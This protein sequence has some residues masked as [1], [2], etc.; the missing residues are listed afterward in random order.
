[1][2]FGVE[3]MATKLVLSLIVTAALASFSPAL[4]QTPV[5]ERIVESIVIN[6]QTAQ[7]V[8]VVQNGGIQ[9]YTCPSP[10][11]YVTPD[12][13]ESGWACFE[14]TTG[15]WLLHAQPPRQTAYAY[16]QA[17]VYVPAPATTVYQYA[18]PYYAYPYSYYPY[19]YYP[20][21]YYPY[22]GSAFGFGFGF[23]YRSPVFV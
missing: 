1:M 22:S 8:L 19:G 14:P 15:M 13:A 9:S 7:G 17:S 12:R 18:P 23:A 16:P 20:Y 10:E 4:A 3:T 5:Q 6:G 21:G 2:L 11:S